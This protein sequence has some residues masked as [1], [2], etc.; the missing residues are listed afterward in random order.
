MFDIEKPRMTLKQHKQAS[1]LSSHLGLD[2][3]AKLELQ[4]VISEHTIQQVSPQPYA[5]LSAYHRDET[6]A[7]TVKLLETL[8]QQTTDQVHI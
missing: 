1:A 2:R 3:F 4:T 7:V 8:P 6:D 5:V